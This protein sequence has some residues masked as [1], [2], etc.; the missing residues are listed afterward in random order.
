MSV[1]RVLAALLL[2]SLPASAATYYVAQTAGVF[3]SGVACNGKTAITVATLNST[4]LNPGD[5][6]YIC[7]TLSASAGASNFIQLSQSGTIASP[8]SIIGDTGAILT[9]TYWS[10]DVF[11]NGG[12]SNIIYNGF[13][14]RATANGSALANKQDGGVCIGNQ[15]TASNITIES[16]TCQNLYVEASPSDNG[17]QSTYCFDI[18]NTTNLTITGNTC[19]DAKWAVANSYNTGTNFGNVNVQIINNNFYNA[20]HYYFL[21]D[22]SSSGT[23]IASGFLIG[24]NLFGSMANWD[25]TADDNHHDLV[26]L[27]ANSSTSSFS[28]IVVNA[29][30]WE[31][32][33]G[34][35]GNA[36][37]FSNRESGGFLGISGV[38]ITNNL[39]VNTSTTHCFADGNVGVSTVSGWTVENNTFVSND[40]GGCTNNGAPLPG[41]SGINPYEGGSTG[42]TWKNNIFQTMNNVFLSFAGAT[43]IGTGDYNVYYTGGGWTG[44]SS[45]NTTSLTTWRTNCAGCDT[46][47]STGNPLLNGSYVPTGTSAI[48]KGVNLT[49]SCVSQPSLCIDAAGNTRPTTGAWDVGALEV[50]FSVTVVA[51]A[52][53]S[54]VSSPAGISCPGTCTASF[55]SGTAV[56]LT[57]T[58]NTAGGYQWSQWISSFCGTP[59]LTTCTFTV[60]GNTLVNATWIYTYPTINRTTGNVTGTCGATGLGTGTGLC[61]PFAP[62]LGNFTVNST[63]HD[64]SLNPTQNCATLVWDANSSGGN[65]VADVS[66]GGGANWVGGSVNGSFL[67]LSVTGAAKI[68][69]MDLSGPCAKVNNTGALSTLGEAY[70]GIGGAIPSQN[71]THTTCA[72]PGC[73]LTGALSASTVADNTYYMLWDKNCTN[74]TCGIGTD[75]WFATSGNAVIY[76]SVIQNAANTG[77]YTG[78][79]LANPITWTS[80]FLFDLR[81]C[82]GLGD[83]PGNINIQSN[84]ALN[85]AN[86][87]QVMGT[88]VSFTGGQDTQRYS[89]VYDASEPSC[90]TWDTLTGWIYKTLN[91]TNALPGD[92]TQGGPAS[93]LVNTSNGALGSCLTNCVAI[94][95]TP[96]GA[97]GFEVGSSTVVIAGTAYTITGF[98]DGIRANTSETNTARPGYQ[99]VAY[100]TVS[101]TPAP[102]TSGFAK[103]YTQPGNSG[104][105]GT[106]NVC[107]IGAPLGQAWT[108]PGVGLH[109]EEIRSANYKVTSMNGAF[110]C[111]VSTP[112]DA[113]LIWHFTDNAVCNVGGTCGTDPVTG[114]ANPTTIQYALPAAGGHGVSGYIYRLWYNDPSPNRRLYDNVN[115]PSTLNCYTTLFTIAPGSQG[116]HDM[117][118]PDPL[119]LDTGLWLANAEGINNAAGNTGFGWNNPP[120][121]PTENELDGLLGWQTGNI[122]TAPLTSLRFYHNDNAEN[123]AANYAST[124]SE[125]VVINSATS[126]TFTVAHPFPACLGATCGTLR[127]TLSGC[128][129]YAALNSTGTISAATATTFTVTGTGTSWTGGPYSSETC[130]VISTSSPNFG[131]KTSI[132]YASSQTGS[133]AVLGYDGFGQLGAD[134]AGNPFCSAMVVNLSPSM[135]PPAT[136]IF[137]G[138]QWNHNPPVT[139]SPWPPTVGTGAN[140]TL[141]VNRFHDD[142]AGG[143][144]PADMKWASMES[145]LNVWTTCT[146][147]AFTNFL[148]TTLPTYPMD[149][150]WTWSD[151]PQWASQGADPTA[152]GGSSQGAYGCTPTTDVDSSSSLC[153]ANTST[154]SN[155]AN[156]GNGPNMIWRSAIY[157]R[158]QTL[159]GVPG[160]H[161]YEC[162]NEPDGAGN[163]WSNA[164]IF[165]GTGHAPAAINVPQLIRLAAMCYDLQQLVHQLDPV[166]GVVL[167]VSI[168]G[169]PFLTWAPFYAGTS[170]D[171]S[172]CTGSC[173][174]ALGGATWAAS[175]CTTSSCNTTG[176]QAMGDVLNGH[177]RGQP[178]SGIG[179]G[180]P[181]EFLLMLADAETFI[182]TWHPN[183]IN[184]C[185]V[186]DEWGPVGT[187]QAINLDTTTA[188]MGIGLVLRAAVKNP[189]ILMENYY[190]WDW[191]QGNPEVPQGTEIGTANNVVASWVT[192]S[193]LSAPVPSTW[194]SGCWNRGTQCLYTIALTTASG[195]PDTIIFDAGQNCNPTCTTSAVSTTYA[196][197][198]TLDGMTHSV[199]GGVVSV[200]IKPILLYGTVVAPSALTGTAGVTATQGTSLIQH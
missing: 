114:N 191:F 74:T 146:E 49:S 179:N 145:S 159:A 109:G 61:I 17:G 158:I 125:S 75:P 196:N 65:S 134:L 184:G 21:T 99:Y 197:Y 42:I 200:G 140:A 62:A 168:H 188:Y 34:L 144:S 29:N 92:P 57:E 96:T 107:T 13:T 50:T 72:S 56:T 43:N 47:S 82:P 32:D 33:P 130:Q 73:T 124:A 25:N 9:A 11:N 128:T 181:T 41:D 48:G 3:G 110:T 100:S 19:H 70:S 113:S 157:H 88:G 136:P 117:S 142:T 44:I 83:L 23:A 141:Y 14:V 174:T 160:P 106:E 27:S 150:L 40:T 87:D 93:G 95:G 59:T 156:C 195:Q 165:G 10:G 155:L 54:V 31:G 175:T 152:C 90:R 139:G 170:F 12:Q 129:V 16:V 1:V 20:D 53:G 91:P 185:M 162:W 151:T 111:V 86:N 81:T 35:N 118:L 84:L 77:P 121:T 161:Y 8:I 103:V 167:S 119:Q 176:I 123:V 199:I 126:A 116:T 138:S 2:L 60:A 28:S 69:N 85:V 26:H 63:A 182:G 172:G 194:T 164:V 177:L 148:S 36:G 189:C 183:L 94:S 104:Y 15:G 186:D 46:H 132:F 18:W 80:Q 68:L 120:A 169:P 52:G 193:T 198:M 187:S 154:A 30:V 4:T 5:T 105:I 127:V 112:G 147:T 24:N 171:D 166:S 71:S 64:A 101:V 135:A 58:A 190:Q 192:G 45:P 39:F 102:G 76:K 133:W 97:L 149:V 66:V 143:C 7:G 22:S 38:S 6:V 153:N 173:S 67:V 137:F 55:T 180:D 131:C 115:C 37:V 163:F 122:N 98:F 178:G 79:A 108:N 78:G 51:S 89:L